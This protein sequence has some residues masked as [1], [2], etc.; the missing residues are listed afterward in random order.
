MSSLPNQ[1]AAR[2]LV[3]TVLAEPHGEWA[4]S[5][6]YLLPPAL[7]TLKESLPKAELLSATAA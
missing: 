1:A 2:R 5:R 6:R 7:P 3:G 4:L